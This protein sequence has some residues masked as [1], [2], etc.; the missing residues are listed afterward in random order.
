[1]NVNEYQIGFFVWVLMQHKKIFIAY[2]QIG[3]T[4]WD[5]NLEFYDLGEIF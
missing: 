5:S 3:L 2:P 1:M 4:H